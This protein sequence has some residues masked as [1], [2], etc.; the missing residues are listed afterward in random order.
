MDVQFTHTLESIYPSYSWYTDI[1]K[2]TGPWWRNNRLMKEQTSSSY[3]THQLKPLWNNTYSLV[4][5]QG[6]PG[7]DPGF[8]WFE[9]GGGGSGGMFLW[10]MFWNL[11]CWRCH[12]LGFR[13]CFKQSKHGL[14]KKGGCQLKHSEL[15]P[16]PPPPRSIPGF[17]TNPLGN[18]H[19]DMPPNTNL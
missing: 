8:C 12:F 17:F 2:P 9:F 14:E 19:D 18:W 6:F 10:E 4:S 15:P 5:I 16:S 1:L 7:A 13:V 11:E 3:K